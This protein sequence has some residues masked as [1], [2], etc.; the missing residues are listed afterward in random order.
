MRRSSLR[1]RNRIY[2]RVFNQAWIATNMP[3][4]ELRRQRAAYRRGAARSAAVFGVVLVSIAVAFAALNETRHARLEAAHAQDAADRRDLARY[5]SMAYG[6]SMNLARDAVQVGHFR[7]ADELLNDQR[8]D[9]NAPDLRGWEWRYLW[10]LCHRSR[11]TIGGFPAKVRRCSSL[12][13]VGSSPLDALARSSSGFATQ[14][15]GA[16]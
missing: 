3:R 8:P 12:H 14:R 7:L 4:R 5:R 11:F 9:H 13:K 1:I 16:R 6:Y 2:A 10:R 15:P